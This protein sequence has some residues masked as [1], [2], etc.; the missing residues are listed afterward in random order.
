MLPRGVGSISGLT[1]WTRY[2][3]LFGTAPGLGQGPRNIAYSFNADSMTTTVA[4]QLVPSEN[5]I[6]TL[7]ADPA[8]RLSAGNLVSTA[9]SRI[10]T[11]PL[12]LQYGLTRWLTI[13]AV[14]PLVETRSTTYGQLNPKL[15]GKPPA[16]AP[17]TPPPCLFGFGANV[18]PNPGLTNPDLRSS[19][20]QLVASFRAAATA[21]QARLT[22]CQ[23]NPTSDCSSL[24]SDPSAVTALIQTT[25]TTATAIETLYGGDPSHPGQLF[26]PLAGSTTESAIEARINGLVTQY[27]TFLPSAVISGTVAGAGGPGARNEMQ[28]MLA[29]VGRDSLQLVDRSSIGDVSVGAT[30]QLFNTFHD[31]TKTGPQARVSVH[32][33]YRFATGEPA[34]RNL[35]FDIG[36]GYGQPGVE[37][38]GAADVLFGG[39]LSATVLGSYTAQLGTIDVARVPT[40]ASLLFPL[41]PAI[42]GTYSAGNVLSLSVLPRWRFAG[43]FVL[44]GEYMLTNVG[45]DNYVP[46]TTVASNLPLGN[47]A[48]T[49]QALGFGFSYSTTGIAN[50]VPRTMPFE[51]SFSHL[52]TLTGTGGPIPKTFRDQITLRVFVGR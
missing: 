35:L 6:R 43:Y 40:P 32:G 39:H 5:A 16:N 3:E 15:C 10:V 50:P 12:I 25:S 33:E 24:L 8:F 34:N 45:A 48:A 31:S 46:V 20:A 19:E 37:V 36:T 18:G 49:T 22:Q 51:V 14:V 9:N 30:L 27:Q 38:G 41:T 26:V 28:Q 52:E 29:I 4:P 47:A 42:P 11:A 13:G 1:S 44:N 7:A 21:L 17:S 2:D 23:T